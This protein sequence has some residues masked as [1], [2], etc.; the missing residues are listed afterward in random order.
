[1][2]KRFSYKKAFIEM[3]EMV[4]EQNKK[5]QKL[6]IDRDAILFEQH[7]EDAT[8]PSKKGGVYYK[9]SDKGWEFVATRKEYMSKER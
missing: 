2:R 4:K 9:N 5:I 7:I 1:M 6:E 8:M 3:R